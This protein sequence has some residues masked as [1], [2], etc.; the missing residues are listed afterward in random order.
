MWP[1]GWIGHE[2]VLLQDSNVGS[3]PDHEDELCSLAR[4]RLGA[5]TDLGEILSHNLDSGREFP[6][7]L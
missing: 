5:I 2:R 4:G 6:P 3:H 1:Y 7:F